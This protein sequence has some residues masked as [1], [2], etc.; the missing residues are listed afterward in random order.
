[1]ARLRRAGAILLGRTN[2]HEFA[3]SALGVNP[4]YGT[5][6][7]PIDPRRVTGGSTSGGGVTVAGGMA[8]INLRARPGVKIAA[9]G[10]GAILRA[11]GSLH[12]GWRNL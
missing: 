4:H 6:R 10:F 7:N 9:G 2:M 3:Y 12:F 1:M 11:T 8:V 5:P